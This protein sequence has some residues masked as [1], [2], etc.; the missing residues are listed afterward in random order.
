MLVIIILAILVF[1]FNIF[2][3]NDGGSYGFG[4]ILYEITF[5]RPM[6]DGE[7]GMSIHLFRLFEIYFKTG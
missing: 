4:A 7:R 6:E 1:P 5:W 2:S 3:Y